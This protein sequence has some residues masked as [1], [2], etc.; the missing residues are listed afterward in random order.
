MQIKTTLALIALAMMP[1]LAVAQGC[2]REKMQSAS[3]CAPGQ[4]FD[5][6]SQTCITPIS[7]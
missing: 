5:A 2:E 3:Q 6:A 1:S 4:T 7:S